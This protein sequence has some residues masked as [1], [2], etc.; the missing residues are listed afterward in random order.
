MDVGCSVEEAFSLFQDYSV[1]L[2]WDPFLCEAYLLD[3]EQAEVG[4]TARCVARPRWLGLSME[5]IYIAYRP[6]HQTAIKM[7]KG[8]PMIAN[9]A[10]SLRHKP[11]P[12]GGSRVIYRYH[13]EAKP[14][15]AAP[16]LDQLLKVWFRIE[17]RKRLQ[18]FRAYVER[19]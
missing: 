1:R 14:R 18:A 16:L 19:R 9:F 15:W 11:L 10:A 6:P 13:F 2:R 3:A 4:A 5:T 7:V 17:T 8:P 12:A